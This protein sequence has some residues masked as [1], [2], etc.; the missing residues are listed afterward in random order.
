M[1]GRPDPITHYLAVGS[2]KGLDPNPL[3]DSQYTYLKTPRW[4]KA[5]ATRW[6]ITWSMG[7]GNGVILT[8]CLIPNTT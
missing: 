8:R 3:F 2:K 4:L 5:A 7:P 1:S 6:P